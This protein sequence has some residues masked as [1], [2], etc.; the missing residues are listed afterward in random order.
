MN[1]VYN[2]LEN[3]GARYNH[4]GCPEDPNGEWLLKINKGTDTLH[5]PKEAIEGGYFKNKMSYPM[6]LKN[7]KD[8]IK[9]L[10]HG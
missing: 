7:L 5:I 9:H 4:R 1:E 2:Y 8:I 3:Q 6:T 10:S